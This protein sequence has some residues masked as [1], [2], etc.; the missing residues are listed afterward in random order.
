MRPLPIRAIVI[1]GFTPVVVVCYAASAPMPKLPHLKTVTPIYTPASISEFI[2]IDS[3]ELEVPWH[4]AMELAK[5]ES[6]L[7]A[8]ARSGDDCGVMQLDQHFFHGA[9]S[10]TAAENIRKGIAYF[11]KL[12]EHCIDIAAKR[13]GV[14]R[15]VVADIDSWDI[16]PFRGGNQGVGV[17]WLNQCATD[18]YRG[19]HR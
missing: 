18:R 4:A 7:R 8:D 3:F 17:E 11:G 5:Q 1:L 2:I 6:G 13:L 19:K 15:R 10:M 12:R 9:C 14:E 16:H